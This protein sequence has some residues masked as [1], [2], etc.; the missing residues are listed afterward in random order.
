MILSRF[1]TRLG[2]HPSGR[3]G[4]SKRGKPLRH[5]KK[6]DQNLSDY[7]CDTVSGNDHTIHRGFSVSMFHDRMVF[8]FPVLDLSQH[9]GGYRIRDIE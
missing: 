8:G 9:T 5:A 3:N 2:G 6:H 4:G 1:Y 7:Q